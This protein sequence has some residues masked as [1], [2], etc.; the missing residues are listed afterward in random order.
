ML[1]QSR[2]AERDLFCPCVCHK[3]KK[4]E[5]RRRNK[6]RRK[7]KKEEEDEERALHGV[8]QL[9]RGGQFTRTAAS[10][11]LLGTEILARLMFRVVR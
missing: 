2:V 6:E 1:L 3:E 11:P 10:T 9:E 8:E 5:R 7:K 4:A